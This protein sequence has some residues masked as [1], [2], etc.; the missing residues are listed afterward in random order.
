V[1]T[2]S[3]LIKLIIFIV[4]TT[5]LTLV[6]GATIANVSVSNTVSYHATFQDATGL[7]AGDDVRIAGVRVGQVKSVKVT[8]S[9]CPCERERRPARDVATAAGPNC[10]YSRRLGDEAPENHGQFV[11]LGV[12][13]G[14]AGPR[15][16]TLSLVPGDDG[17]HPSLTRPEGG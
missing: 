8:T 2:T 7:N 16:R 3:S 4:V 5:L 11:V 13:L 9:A 12:D 15:S 10:G 14:P 17:D 6:L 1:K